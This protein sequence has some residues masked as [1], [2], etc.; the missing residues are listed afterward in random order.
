MSTQLG[1]NATFT[2]S[3]KGLTVLG[4]H[5]YATNYNSA[6][7][8]GTFNALDFQTGK[9]YIIGSFSVGIDNKP[10]SEHEF[11]VKFNNVVIF[12]SKSDNGK[13]TSLVNPFSS[14]IKILVPPN[15]EVKAEVEVNATTPLSVFFV[16][17]LHN[18]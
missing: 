17:E 13:E 7:G 1:S 16:G 10:G 5:A 9:R 11:R 2:G 14:P 12:E 18:G 8:S 3:S 6:Q 4:K 15:T